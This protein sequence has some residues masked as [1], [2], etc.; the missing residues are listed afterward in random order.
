[1][2]MTMLYK[3][4]EESITVQQGLSWDQFIAGVEMMKVKWAQEIFMMSIGKK[5]PNKTQ[6]SK[7]KKSENKN[8]IQLEEMLIE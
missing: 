4:L 7:K 3:L 6:K 5:Q 1:M 8:F 2:I